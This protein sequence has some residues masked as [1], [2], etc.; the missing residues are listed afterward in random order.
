M[1]GMCC[2]WVKCVV[3][4]GNFAEQRLRAILDSGG[5]QVARILHP[6]PANPAANRDWSGT[7][8]RQ[9]KDQGIW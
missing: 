2:D 8:R 3:G 6:S 7:A 4:V 9:L 1:T 5:I